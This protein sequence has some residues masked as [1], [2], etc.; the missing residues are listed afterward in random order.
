VLCNINKHKRLLLTVLA[1]ENSKTEIDSTES[2]R[3]IQ[4]TISPRYHGAEIAVGPIP[5]RIGETLEMKG[6]MFHV[7]NVR[8]ESRKG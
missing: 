3:S 6:N 7:Y 1:A 2:G 8:R 4:E 5:A